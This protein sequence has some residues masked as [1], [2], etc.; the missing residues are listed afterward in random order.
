MRFDLTDLRLFLA[1]ADAGSITHGAQEIG[2]SLAAASD[3]LREMELAGGVA[4]LERGRRGIRLTEAGETLSHH[5][6][7]IIGHVALMRADLGQFAKGLRATIRMAV[8]TAAMVDTLPQR[9]TPWLADHPQVDIDLR[10]RQSHEIARSVT[11]GFADI[12]ILSDVAAHEALV[13]KSFATSQ[14]AIVSAKSHRLA[15][16][17]HVRFESLTNDYFI[18][19]KDG[20]LQAHI[21]SQAEKIG[22]RLRYRISLRTYESICHAASAGLGIAIVPSTIAHH[23]KR[24]Y[25]LSVTP[26]ADAWARRNLVVCIARDAEQTPLVR[27]LF[28]HLSA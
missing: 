4:L 23:C 26:L 28:E 24:S 25:P 3:R 5:A 16:E 8:N 7:Q 22:A 6:R 20:A 17:K 14:L 19:L 18:G 15:N 27:D 2:L 11:A 12:G 21:E 13:F 1:V 9:L 10:E